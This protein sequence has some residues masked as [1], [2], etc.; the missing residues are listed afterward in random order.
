MSNQNKFIQN[1]STKKWIRVIVHPELKSVIIV[2][3]AVAHQEPTGNAETL[4]LQLE[5]QFIIHQN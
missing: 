1:P 3:V 2:D 5:K 4:Y